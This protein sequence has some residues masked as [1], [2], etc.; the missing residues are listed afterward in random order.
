MSHKV[1]S[2]SPRHREVL[3]RL[4]LGQRRIEIARALGM[5]VDTISNLAHSEPGSAYLAKLR[6]EM[7]QHVV[8]FASTIQLARSAGIL[9]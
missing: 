2:L 3:R 7:D 6:E 4:S 1:K 8:R 9:K 5:N